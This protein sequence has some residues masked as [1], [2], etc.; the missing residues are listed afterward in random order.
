MNDARYLNDRA[1]EKTDFA[2]IP[3]F[4][5]F[6]FNKG[7]PKPLIFLFLFGKLVICRQNTYKPSKNL[8]ISHAA[9]YLR[10]FASSYTDD[11]VN[12]ARVYPM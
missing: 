2:I 4:R 7:A 12:V 1:F 9:L 10:D 5:F 8:I 6:S 3:N 11:N